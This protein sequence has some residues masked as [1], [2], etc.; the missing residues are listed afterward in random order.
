M[1]LWQQWTKY[2]DR[3]KTEDKMIQNIILYDR[4]EK[5]IYHLN[6]HVAHV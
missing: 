3:D 1:D 6:N 5:V 2:V 4:Q